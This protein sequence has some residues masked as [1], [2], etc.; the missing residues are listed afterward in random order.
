M[1]S[2]MSLAITFLMLIATVLSLF[3]EYQPHY[4][5][6]MSFCGFVG[7]LFVYLH[8]RDN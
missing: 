2:T 8:D 4:L 3:V 1:M 5:P 6:A 7:W